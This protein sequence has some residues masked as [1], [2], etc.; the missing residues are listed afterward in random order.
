MPRASG[1]PSEPAEP[2]RRQWSFRTI[3]LAVAV[4]IVLLGRYASSESREDVNDDAETYVE[5]VERVGPSIDLSK[6]PMWAFQELLAA[7]LL[8][9]GQPAMGLE[10]GG[11]EFN[12]R[13]VGDFG[14]ATRCIHVELREDQAPVIVSA[15]GDCTR[16]NLG[17]PDE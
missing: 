5:L 2:G 12:K 9:T 8:S 16:Q 3:L 15:E 7:G 13:I 10:G 17:T 11:I 14:S 1:D 6:G 4:V